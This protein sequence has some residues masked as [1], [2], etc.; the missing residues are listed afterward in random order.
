MRA[1]AWRALA[2]VTCAGALAGLLAACAGPRE[3]PLPPLPLHEHFDRAT[4]VGHT[5]VLVYWASWCEFCERNLRD[6]SALAAR[7]PASRVRFV[8]LTADDD[9]AA[10]QAFSDRVGLRFPNYFGGDEEARRDGIQSLTTALLVGPDGRVVKRYT[11]FAS[12]DLARLEADLKA[13]PAR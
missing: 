2:R 12:G 10:A 4:L 13:L 9:H 8:G 5:T 7:T 3:A 6:I 11:R 1:L